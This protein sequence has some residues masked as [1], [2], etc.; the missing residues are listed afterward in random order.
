MKSVC[1]SL[2]ILVASQVIVSPPGHLYPVPLHPVPVVPSVLATIAI[3]S[4]TS[5]LY[6]YIVYVDKPV[7]CNVTA[8]PDAVSGDVT[9]GV[10]GYVPSSVLKYKLYVNLSAFSSVAIDSIVI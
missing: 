6:L 4:V 7:A 3:P 5:T 9:F 1:S 2:Y 8:V 10:L